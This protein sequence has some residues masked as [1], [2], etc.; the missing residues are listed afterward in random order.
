[1][2]DKNLKHSSTTGQIIRLF[3]DS[4]NKYGYGFNQSIYKNSFAAAIRNSPIKYQ[5]DKIIDVHYEADIIGQ[6]IL[7]F[8]VDEKIIVLISSS[9]QIEDKELKKLY[10][11]LKVSQYEIGILLNYGV[12]PEHRRRD[13][14]NL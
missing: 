2:A 7:D 12:N 13:L 10:N 9:E 5:K 8:V 3:Y 1:M 11:F 4:Y 6:V 14:S